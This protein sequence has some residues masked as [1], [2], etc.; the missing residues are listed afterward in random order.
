[1]AIGAST[2]RSEMEI[3]LN[4]ARENPKLF[5]EYIVDFQ[6]DHPGADNP[7]DEWGYDLDLSREGFVVF[8]AWRKV[9]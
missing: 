5:V 7:G 8:I 3:N 2:V 4:W 1:M 9:L 6:K